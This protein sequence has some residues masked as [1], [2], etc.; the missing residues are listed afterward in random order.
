M[1]N[2]HLISLLA[3]SVV[4]AA[5]GTVPQ[6]REEFVH[7]IQNYNGLM[8]SQT[9]VYS[10]EMDQPF[11]KAFANIEDKLA[12]CIPEGYTETSMR[13]NLGF[14]NTVHNNQ[15]IERVSPD[16]AEITIQQ[17]HSD[18][19]RQ[20]EGG[21]YLLAADLFKQGNNKV[22][23]DFYTGKHYASI[24]EAI[25]QWSAGSQKCHGIGGNP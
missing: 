21:S 17:H 22:R 14:S 15:R 10:K 25:E 12:R 20:S 2:I 1:K 16:K 24:A 13:G 23:L 18:T 19:Y 7:A 4:M 5:C 3:I 8:A 11:D 6:S 9:L